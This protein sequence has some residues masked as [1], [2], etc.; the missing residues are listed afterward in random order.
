MRKLF[1]L[2]FIAL[3]M[4]GCGVHQTDV[5]NGINGN[6]GNDGISMGIDLKAAPNLTCDNGGAG[7]TQVSTFVDADKDGLLGSLEEVK[8]IRYVCNGKNGTNG[9]NG[10]NGSNGH[11]GVSPTLTITSIAASPTSGCPTGGIDVNGTKVCNGAVGSQGPTGPVGPTGAPGSSSVGG[12]T[13]VQLCAGDTQTYKE[14][15]L[16]IGGHLY[17]VYYNPPT[18]GF[19]SQL[20]PGS[21]VTTNGV[22]CPFT[23][24]IDS[25][26][27][28]FLNNV[29]LTQM[30]AGLV[31]DVHD[32]PNW[33]NVTL[34]AVFVG[35][36]TKGSFVIPSLSNFNSPA[37]S[38][39][40]Y[41]PS[42]LQTLV[43]YEG[44]SLDING[45]LNVPT[46]GKYIFKMT[47]DD[48]AALLINGVRII[49][50][51]SLHS[52]HEAVSIAV[53][54][55]KGQNFIN[56]IYYQGPQSQ[57]ALGLKWSGP[58]LTEQVIPA[59]ALSH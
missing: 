3:A 53:D 21:Y 30:S 2:S 18:M 32:I 10:S 7:G 9:S 37:S 54:L 25:T 50:D 49:S 20:Q 6:N 14:Y 35:N 40:P 22:A 41:M 33:D 23:Y 34:P 38:G 48:G 29:A 15:G 11:D 16:L 17:A 51:D 26:G 5:I 4:T 56:V 44:Y 39:F 36:P 12:V 57:I 45:Y 31:A 46:T 55:V 59:S 28:Q 13:P 42:A 58:N 24:T 52:P 43:G 47:S 27:N 8:Q 1:M 19:L